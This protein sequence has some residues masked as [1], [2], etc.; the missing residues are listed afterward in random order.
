MLQDRR[1]GYAHMNEA[2]IAGSTVDRREIANF[3]A[4]AAQWWNEDG[5]MAA[6][7]RI[8]PLRLG[9]LRDRLVSH[10]SLEVS[11]FKPLKNIKILDAGCGGGLLSEPLARMGA[12]VTAIDAGAEVLEAAQRHTEASGLDIDYRCTTA[13]ALAATGERFDAVTSME[14]IEHVADL[15]AFVAAL[16]ELTRPGGALVL[17]TL[18]RTARSLALA[19]FGAEYVLRWVPPGTHDWGK[20]VKPAELRR[21]LA[22][23]GAQVTDFTGISRRIGGGWHLS[24]DLSINYLAFAVRAGKQDA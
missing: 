20:F 1:Q 9:Y 8:N 6:L 12:S 17:S 11:D 16:A 22:A 24:Q 5:P 2:S 14:V 4:L 18:N 3:D 10:L 23:G 19:K 15:P 7:H 13:E 21:M